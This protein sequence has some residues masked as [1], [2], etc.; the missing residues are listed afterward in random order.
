MTSCNDIYAT[1]SNGIQHGDVFTKTCVVEYMLDIVGYTADKDLSHISIA[2]PSCGEGEFLMAIL[3]R[4]KQSSEQYLFDFNAAFRNCIF[5]ADIDGRK[6]L[7]CIK[8]IQNHYPELHNIGLNVLV[9]D[10]LLHQHQLV[11][12]IVGN[13]PYI[14]YEQIPQEVR[15][16]YKKKF[17]TFYYRA[18]MYVL[19]FEH[20]LKQLKPNGK[21]CF[22]CAN[23]WLKNTYGIKLRQLIATHFHIRLIINLEGANAFNQQVLAYPAITLIENNRTATT[24]RLAYATDIYRLNHINTREVTSPQGQDWSNVFNTKD[25]YSQ[26]THIEE[27][28]FQIGIGVATGAD[29]I[30]ISKDIRGT[31]EGELLI[32]SI[33][34][35][36]L[37]G[38]TLLWGGRFLINPYDK[39]GELIQLNRYPRAKAYLESHK[40]ILAARHKARKNPLK[41][42]ATID[43]I[44]P[45]LTTMPKILLPDI[46][47]NS[48]IFV[49]DGHFYPQH[50]IYY[51]TGKSYNQLCLLAAILMSDFVRKQLD[52]LTNHMNGGYA[53][54]QSQYIKQ[55]QIPNIDNIPTQTGNNLLYS[56][57]ARDIQSINQYVSEIVNK[58]IDTILQ[59]TIYTQPAL[60]HNRRVSAY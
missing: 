17:A 13:P 14:R 5:A 39:N 32:P 50:N 38:N 31:V 16:V 9:E 2:E 10:Y 58:P 12:I 29:G 36:D 57:R 44:T 23:R 59:T 6:I 7:T 18:D 56:Y 1:R 53:R 27:Q 30:F 49:D 35:R 40:D 55:L 15:S 43:K 25:A 26:L 60:H 54:W 46:S 19:F 41:W 20:S 47:G 45:E 3:K 24:T 21:H 11:D 34:A 37:R 33:N 28:E 8:R 42:Y 51:I 22:I 4:L 52:Q 48:Y